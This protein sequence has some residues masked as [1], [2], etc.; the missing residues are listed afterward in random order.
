M[1][2]TKYIILMSMI[3]ACLASQ[4]LLAQRVI[5]DLETNADLDNIPN[6]TIEGGKKKKRRCREPWWQVSWTRFQAHGTQL[7]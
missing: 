6:D 3:L 5:R 7:M 1:L 2:K 4:D